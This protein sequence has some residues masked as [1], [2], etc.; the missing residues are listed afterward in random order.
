MTNATKY[1]RL[2][3]LTVAVKQN[4]QRPAST[5]QR[6]DNNDNKFINKLKVEKT[7]ARLLQNRGTRS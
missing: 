1:K 4:V 7:F 2:Q 5:F 6:S 3:N